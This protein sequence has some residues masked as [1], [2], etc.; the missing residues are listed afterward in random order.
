MFTDKMDTMAIPERV[1]LLYS[2]VKERSIDN[3][4]LRDRVM[5]GNQKNNTDYYSH[6]RKCAEELNLISINDN[7]ISINKKVPELQSIKD[8]RLYINNNLELFKNGNFYR[9]TQGVLNSDI[10]EIEQLKSTEDWQTKLSGLAGRN[11]DD[12]ET[13]GWKFWIT[14]LGFGVNP[15]RTG[16]SFLLN[17]AIFL[18]DIICSTNLDL[19]KE[20]QM[21]DF[22]E[23]II[24]KAN[25]LLGDTKSSVLNYSASSGLRSLHDLGFIK[26]QH[27]LDKGHAWT[28]DK[29]ETH[30]I[31]DTINT[32]TILK[33][34]EI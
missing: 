12:K 20:Y 34:E 2:M 27:G 26:L 6:T 1:F 18:E 19:N 8:M 33:K 5:P 14:F 24:P 23:R 13:N 30:E 3:S 4:K 15:S 21:D 16:I 25:I 10:S 11:I 9:A 22:M 29:M 7:T 32:I 28:L 17:A 31:Q